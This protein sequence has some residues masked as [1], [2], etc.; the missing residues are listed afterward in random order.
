LDLDY[1]YGKNQ[2]YYLKTKPQEIKF[3]NQ[4]RRYLQSALILLDDEKNLARNRNA[5]YDSLEKALS[6][7]TYIINHDN[8]DNDRI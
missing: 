1:V 3:E 2:T 6:Y 8:I 7:A 5:I 4:A